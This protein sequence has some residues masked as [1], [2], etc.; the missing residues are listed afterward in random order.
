MTLKETLEKNDEI[1]SQIK[2]LKN[3][4]KPPTEE[5]IKEYLNNKGFI[6]VKKY[7]NKK[8]PRGILK[9]LENNKIYYHPEG[10]IFNHDRLY[11]LKNPSKKNVNRFLRSEGQGYCLG[12]DFIKG[13]PLGILTALGTY[14]VSSHPAIQNIP[15][16]ILQGAGFVLGTSL[17]ALLTEMCVDHLNPKKKILG[18]GEKDLQKLVEICEE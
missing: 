16:Y 11:Q 2:N 1:D 5:D 4:R 13:I 15:L 10:Y 8:S 18:Y 6:R 14:F 12:G 7:F 3:D 17:G 9:Y